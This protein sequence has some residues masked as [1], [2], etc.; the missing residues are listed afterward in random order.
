[1]A[2]RRIAS[3]EV[4]NI[5]GI[6]HAHFTVGSLSIL[7]GANGTGK[8]SVLN[9]VSAVFEG[10]HD[11]TLLRNGA[12]EGFVKITLSDGVTITKRIT[13]KDSKLEIRAADGSIVPKPASFVERLASG[14]ACDPIAFLGADSKKRTKFLLDVLPV[15]FEP[16]E[17]ALA[18]AG[19]RPAQR[20][21]IE[22]LENFRLGM[23]EDRRKINVA[24]R[25]LEGAVQTMEKSLPA[26]I[27]NGDEVKARAAELRTQ[28]GQLTEQIAGLK[29]TIKEQIAAAE[30]QAKAEYEAKL[31]QIIKDAQQ[32]E[33]D[34]TNSLN[35]EAQKVYRQMLEAEEQ[36]NAVQRASGVL[37]SIDDMRQRLKGKG[38]EG[39]AITQALE[40]IQALKEKKLAACDLGGI[41]IVDGE[42][43]VDGISLDSLNTQKQYFIAFQIAALAASDL[44]FMVCDRVESIV[45]Q[46]WEEF[47]AAAKASG[48]QVIT[49]RAEEDVSLS[50]ESDG[51]FKLLVGVGATAKPMPKRKRQT[52][53]VRAPGD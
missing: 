40:G 21:N 16:E 7:R 19:R 38:A 35:A 31:G 45:G 28:H 47:Q 52:A 17:V 29:R 20:L 49:A 22:G 33:W 44:A 13:T 34:E 41:E 26:S 46:Q 15:V 42:I 12:V 10:G 48:F 1:M 5:K 2:S 11:P 3:V 8:T 24:Y 43:R 51:E 27:Q 4:E 25:E 32:A 6:E 14:F 39:D 30:A 23:Y 9:G 18:A 50:V 36:S 53:V 37:K